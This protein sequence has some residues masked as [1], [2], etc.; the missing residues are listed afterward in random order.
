MTAPTAYCP[1]CDEPIRLRG[2][3]ALGMRVTCP[4]CGAEL[5][6][7][8]LKPLELDWVYDY[9]EEEEEFEEEFEEEEEGEEDFD[10]YSDEDEY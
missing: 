7:V 3:V 4:S 10:E 9:E 8:S 1:D 5:E 6:V 2:K